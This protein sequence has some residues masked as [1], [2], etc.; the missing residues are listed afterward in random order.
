MKPS[1]NSTKYNNPDFYE[2][3]KTSTGEVVTKSTL[4]RD[5]IQSSL[6]NLG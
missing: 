6:E 5:L 4:S 2:N 1:R 3:S